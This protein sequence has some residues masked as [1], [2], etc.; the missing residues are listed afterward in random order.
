MASKYASLVKLVGKYTTY[1]ALVS[2]TA[3]GIITPEVGDGVSI[4][5]S[6]DAKDCNKNKIFAGSIVVWN[7]KYWLLMKPAQ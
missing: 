1:E 4:N 5:L 2:D 3:D 7:G 6:T